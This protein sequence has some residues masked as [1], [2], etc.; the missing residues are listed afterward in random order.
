[1][2]NKVGRI[3]VRNIDED[4]VLKLEKKAKA[5][6]LSREA[7]VRN[8]LIVAAQMDLLE[9]QQNR[10]ETLLREYIALAKEQGEIIE[11]NSLLMDELLE[12]I[13]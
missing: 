13:Y 12:K 3:D 5:N 2:K 8:I 4:V 6:G 11:K 1:M 9:E 10:Y 7:Y